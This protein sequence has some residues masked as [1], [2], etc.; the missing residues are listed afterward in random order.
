[1][2]CVGGGGGTPRGAV[3]AEFIADLD[4]PRTGPVTA[5]LAQSAA[6]PKARFWA[7]IQSLV[8]HQLWQ[9]P[10]KL[11]NLRVL[12]AKHGNDCAKPL[13]LSV[14]LCVSVLVSLSRSVSLC[15]S[16]FMCLCVSLC[17]ALSLCPFCPPTGSAA[18]TGARLV[19]DACG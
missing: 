8:V 5:V 11:A 9:G 4:I 17:F 14:S 7:T 13:C 15:L 3:Q 6:D 18:V 16:V 1:M 19:R 12:L 10:G 2:C